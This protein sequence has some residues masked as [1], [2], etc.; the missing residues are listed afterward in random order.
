MT[1]G[2]MFVGDWDHNLNIPIALVNLSQPSLI[3]WKMYKKRIQKYG[4]PFNKFN[5]VWQES[6]LRQLFQLISN[7]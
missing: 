5:K 2:F 3:D 4:S 7:L 1:P 6:K